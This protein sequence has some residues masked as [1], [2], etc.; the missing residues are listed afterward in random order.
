MRADPLKVCDRAFEIDHA[1]VCRRQ[2]VLAYQR[3]RAEHGVGP[4]AMRDVA[5]IAI[6]IGTIPEAPANFADLRLECLQLGCI[7]KRIEFSR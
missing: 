5:A 2:V 4:D 1:D 7:K 3:G 6:D